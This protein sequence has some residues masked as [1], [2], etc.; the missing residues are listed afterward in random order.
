MT[1]SGAGLLFGL[2]GR[3]PTGNCCVQ[4]PGDWSR[5]QARVFI[6]YPDLIAASRPQ[7][8]GQR[9]P[10]LGF[11]GCNFGSHFT[12]LVQINNMRQMDIVFRF[13]SA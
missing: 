1:I 6:L 10:S 12:S 11:T 4:P 8:W 9:L 13:P 5:A 7:L 2:M 3:P